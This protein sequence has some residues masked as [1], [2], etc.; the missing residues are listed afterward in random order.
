[1]AFKTFL[2]VAALL[3]VTVKAE[4]PLCLQPERG[5]T[6]YSNAQYIQ[7]ADGRTLSVCYDDL[8]GAN[9]DNNWVNDISAILQRRVNGGACC[10]DCSTAAAEGC[11]GASKI[12]SEL[13]H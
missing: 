5:G 12:T 8:S 6:L 9:I 7:V 2:G 11:T 3:A 1:M 13:R 4:T 10:I